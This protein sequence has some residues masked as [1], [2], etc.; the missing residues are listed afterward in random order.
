MADSDEYAVHSKGKLKLKTDTEKS[1]K[2]RKKRDKEKIEKNV[3]TNEIPRDTIQINESSGSRFTKA[4]LAFKKMQ[5]KTQNKR[6]MERA[7]QTHKQV[8]N[9]HSIT[10]RYNTT[11]SFLCSKSRNSTRSWISLQSTLTSR[12]SHG[13]N[14]FRF[15]IMLS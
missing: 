14:N 5:E 6:I 1:K 8:G 13:Q 10:I 4:E 9:G 2:K 7:S 12:R 11:I 15:Y 3:T